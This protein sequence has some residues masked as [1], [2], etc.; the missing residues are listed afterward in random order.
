[1]N[2][3]HYLTP[4]TKINSKLNKDFMVSIK[5]LEEHI[6]SKLFDTGLRDFW[7]GSVFSSE[8]DKS[9][10]KQMELHHHKRLL[11]N[12]RNKTKRQPNEWEKIF[13]NDISGKGLICKIYKEF[14]QLS[15]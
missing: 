10:N 9:K 5:P 6:V 2:W 1:M 8:G 11:H 7:G 12:E 13:A 3:G 15:L 4:Y 14:K